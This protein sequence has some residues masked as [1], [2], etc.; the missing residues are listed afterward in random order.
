MLQAVQLPAGVTN[1][2]SGLA[3]MD[4]DTLTHGA[5]VRMEKVSSESG[6]C[7]MSP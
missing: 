1:L 5:E 2:G 4:G 3:N 6:E 7:K